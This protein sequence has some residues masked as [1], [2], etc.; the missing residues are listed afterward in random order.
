[1]RKLFFLAGL[2]FLC[3]QLNGQTFDYGVKA[4]IN[5]S[6]HLSEEKIEISTSRRPLFTFGFQSR[7]NFNSNIGSKLEFVFSQAGTN[8]KGIG[9]YVTLNRVA[10][11]LLVQLKIHEKLFIG[12]GGEFSEIHWVNS[13]LGFDKSLYEKNDYGLLFGLEYELENNLSI[14]LRYYHGLLYHNEIVLYDENAN[15]IGSVNNDKVSLFSLTINY[16]LKR[17]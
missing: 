14:D 11:P 8:Y 4:G 13:N 3:V 1:M 6:K 12:V 7:L 2:L 9:G 5:Y 15:E 17:N 10:V 16:Y